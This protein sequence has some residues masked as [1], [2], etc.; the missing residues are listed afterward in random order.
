MS[1]EK[2]SKELQNTRTDST[3]AD[4]AA[5]SPLSAP[6]HTIS[7]EKCI[8]AF[9]TDSK[10]GLSES[11]VAEL[12]QKYGPNQLKEVPPPSLIKILIRNTLNAM[13]IVLIAAMAVSFGTQDWISGGVIFALV[14]INVGVSTANEW[15]AEKTVAAL[16]D[17]GS[18]NAVVVRNSGGE[19]RTDTIKTDKVV[20]GDIIEIKI[21][22]IVPADARIIPEFLS[23]LD[24]DE[25][26]L[27]GESLPVS[28]TSDP[29][30][31]PDCPVGD[32]TCMVYSGSQVTKGR[33]R[34][35][36]TGT[37]MMTELGK[38]SAAM[39][40]KEARKEK[41]WR[42][43]LFKVKKAMGIAD[44]TP[45][46]IKLNLLAYILL[47]VACLLALIVV[48][49]TAFDN[50]PLSIA[51]YAV[52]TAVS[53]L[54]ASL[55]AVVALSLA[56]ASKELAKRNAL[57]R[58]MDA[59]E[60][61]AA[62]TDICS[63]KT[64]T[65]TVGKMVMKK[66]WVPFLDNESGEETISSE[67][68]QLYTVES[69]QDPYYPRGAVMAT[70]DLEADIQADDLDALDDNNLVTPSDMPPRL[71]DFVLCSSLCNTATIQKSQEEGGSGKW[72]ANGDATEIALIV[73]A[74]KLGHGRPYLLKVSRP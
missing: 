51:T 58:K 40:R 64:G 72:E 37:A 44:T 67:K 14:V 56:N 55:I 22:D 30:D 47:A 48:A 66:A 17:V 49:S 25:A 28:K 13:T 3:V 63:D 41:G 27:T 59:I 33:A 9:E 60:T 70:D 26:L 53:L 15:S 68:G 36:V 46:Q 52:A 43:R 73:F 61:L 39:E 71:R 11:K 31:D 62:V 57:V 1:K 50:V 4:A 74:Y 20:P 7:A 19:G 69:G 34:C 24:V 54:P 21:G 18:P 23:S 45:L 35:V 29:I 12:Q 2:D 6:P 10:N 16:G 32:R 5:S 38:I 65:L 42:Y 8:R